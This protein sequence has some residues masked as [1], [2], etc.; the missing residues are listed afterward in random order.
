MHFDIY[1][2]L[3]EWLLSDW[4]IFDNLSRPTKRLHV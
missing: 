1:I 2:L 3:S 4:L